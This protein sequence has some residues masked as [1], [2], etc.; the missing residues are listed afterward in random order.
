MEELHHSRSQETHQR[1]YPLD[2]T[3]VYPKA[4]SYILAN[5]TLSPHHGYKSP[6][7]PHS[8][9]AGFRGLVVD[10][11]VFCFST[12]L[13]SMHNKSAQVA[14]ECQTTW[15]VWECTRIKIGFLI[16]ESC[17]WGQWEECIWH[18]LLSSPRRYVCWS[19]HRRP[20]DITAEIGQIPAGDTRVSRPMRP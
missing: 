15:S 11:T 20:W 13:P 17:S 1:N 18:S 9:P 7:A 3:G 10:Y 12:T 4:R 14:V 5:M 16:P 6:M 19:L 2:I 8:T